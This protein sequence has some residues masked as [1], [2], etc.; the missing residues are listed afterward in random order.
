MDH[1]DLSD[2]KWSIDHGIFVN[3]Y[4]RIRHAQSSQLHCSPVT[5]MDFG[6]SE[7]LSQPCLVFREY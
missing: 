5:V 7:P 4:M 6:A 3:A 2:G 1:P